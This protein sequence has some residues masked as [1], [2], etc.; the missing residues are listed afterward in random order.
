MVLHRTFLAARQPRHRFVAPEHL[1][2]QLLR[3]KA[4]TQHL[5]NRSIPAAALHVHLAEYLQ[6]VPTY[7]P[8][9]PVADTQPTVDFQKA[10]QRSILTAH[11]Q[12]R[13]E[14]TA[15]DM[16]YAL[17]D[18]SLELSITQLVAKVIAPVSLQAVRDRPSQL[19]TLCGELTTQESWTVVPGRGVLCA[20]C[21]DAIDSARRA[22]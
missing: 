17:V 19:C 6:S 15:L 9:D 8:D 7:P 1:L 10:V 4:V 13:K 5:A 14:A 18:P 12:G 20:E 16:L 22:D 21:V 2:F 3:E 11:H